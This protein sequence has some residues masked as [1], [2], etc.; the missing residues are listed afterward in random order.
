MP[1]DFAH[2]AFGRSC[3]P[4]VVFIT[5]TQVKRDMSFNVQ[6][7]PQGTGSGFFWDDQG[8]L[9]SALSCF[10]P[11]RRTCLVSST[12]Q[13][14]LIGSSDPRHIVTNYHVIKDAQRA[15]AS[16]PVRLEALSV[17]LA[18]RM[19]LAQRVLL[20]CPWHLLRKA[21]HDNAGHGYPGP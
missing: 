12:T 9:A 4:S 17:C 14:Q 11:P 18:L 8:Y 16:S 19:C 10:F 1:P 13:H 5:T 7:I 15:Q 6:E 3:A 21:G 2:S 20:P